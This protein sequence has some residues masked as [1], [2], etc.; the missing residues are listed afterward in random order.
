MM[1][2]DCFYASGYILKT[3]GTRTNSLG[4]M[5]MVGTGCVRQNENHANFKIVKKVLLVLKQTIPQQK[6][7]DFSF[8]L[9]P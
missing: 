2:L 5:S 4:M 9:A 6:T 8:N 1:K 7:L 3:Q